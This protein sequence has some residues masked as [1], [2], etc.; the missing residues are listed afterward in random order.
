MAGGAAF[1]ARDNEASISSW[2]RFLDCRKAIRFSRGAFATLGSWRKVTAEPT[3]SSRMPMLGSAESKGSTQTKCYSRLECARAQI[4]GPQ[5]LGVLPAGLLDR[6][7]KV[8]SLRERS[9]TCVAR[10]LKNLV[11]IEET[12][13]PIVYLTMLQGTTLGH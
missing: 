13:H 5:R 2:V 4:G 6:R 1:P 10:G 9:C 8:T 7:R 11:R 12:F 3:R